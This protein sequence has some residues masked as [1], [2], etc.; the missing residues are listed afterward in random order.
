MEA[1]A[2]LMAESSGRSAD[3]GTVLPGQKTKLRPANL[4]FSL[5][6]LLKRFEWSRDSELQYWSGSIPSAKTFQEFQRLLPER[7]W[8]PDGRRRSYAILDR[9]CELVGMVSCYALDWGSGTGELGVYIGDRNRWGEGLGTD[10]IRTLLQHFF[11]ELG[12]RS[13]H[14]NTY[15]TNLRALRSYAKLGFHKT[16]ARRRFRPS[17]GYYREVRMELTKDEFENASR[18]GKTTGSFR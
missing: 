5:Q 18:A 17:V 4:G 2:M 3:S 14:L 10:A 11:Q 1:L 8:P 16:A 15:A 9:S 7:D 6:E 12:F 13:I